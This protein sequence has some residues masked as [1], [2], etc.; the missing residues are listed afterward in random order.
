MDQD[1]IID[2]YI[3]CPLTSPINHGFMHKTLTF[4]CS[5]KLTAEIWESNWRQL[6]NSFS[7]RSLSTRLQL[8]KSSGSRA[9]SFSPETPRNRCC[10]FV[11]KKT[12]QNW[13][14]VRTHSLFSFLAISGKEPAWVAMSRT[15]DDLKI[16]LELDNSAAWMKHTTLSRVLKRN[17]L[18]LL[19]F[20][21]K[22][23]EMSDQHWWANLNTSRLIVENCACQSER[24][25]IYYSI[26]K[27]TKRKHAKAWPQRTED[28]GTRPITF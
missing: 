10:Q 11:M 9:S 1:S 25:G 3:F 5:G 24:F 15:T 23:T 17:V 8:A 2:T 16:E 28:I 22:F 26:C 21:K 7:L 27:E 12:Q 14:Y 4:W 6:F 18:F 20:F 13:G 19:T